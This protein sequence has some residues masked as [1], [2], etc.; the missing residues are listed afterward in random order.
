MILPERVLGSAGA[1]WISSGLA[2]LP[3][4]LLTRASSAC[5]SVSSGFTPFIGVTKA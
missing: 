5:L 3:I 2:K 1:H 4:S